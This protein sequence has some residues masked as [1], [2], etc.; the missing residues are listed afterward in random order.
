MIEW[1]KTEFTE[2][3]GVT[4]P[5]IQA[6]MAGITTP[7]LVAA[8][9]KAG[10]V[11]SLG[12]AMMQPDDIRK[13]IHRIRELT[14]R[15]FNVNLFIPRH[16]HGMIAYEAF[17]KHLKQ[18][19][20]EVGFATSTELNPPPSFEKQVEV[21]L[22]EE[23]PIFS[24]TFGIPPI[25]VI[26]DFEKRGALVIGTA[27]HVKEALALQ[28]AGV[29]FIVA[30]GVEAGGHR[31]TFLEDALHP[32]L[33]LLKEIKAQVKKP[34]IAAGG[35]MH[36]KEILSALKA[37]AAAVQMGTAFI[38]CTESG[39]HPAY[40]KALLEWKNRNTVLT[41][42]F[43]GKWARAVENRFTQEIDDVEIPPFPIAQSLTGPMRKAA[44]A[45]HNAEFMSLW[46]GE[47]FRLCKA[48]TAQEL[49]AKL[50][51]EISS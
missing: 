26:R 45:A 33:Q 36:G 6:P 23:V 32:T 22:Q 13:A 35:L 16:P 14:R 39:A 44:A 2:R 10:G 11:G 8:V 12:A 9:S 25:H 30:Q 51:L 5:L 50:T 27:T 20:S 31:G 7:E 38:T 24:F 21:L 19:E 42:A 47:H 18:Y 41:K 3:A 29:D 4:L 17:L 1:P 46:A 43:T 49:I 15:P 28:E 40:K 34:L 48:G 37:G